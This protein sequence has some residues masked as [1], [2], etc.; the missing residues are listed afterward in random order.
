[1]TGLEVVVPTSFVEQAIDAM[2]DVF[3][4]AEVGN[5]EVR[6]QPVERHISDI[7]E[8]VEEQEQAVA[9]SLS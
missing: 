3:K 8:Y 4:R 2:S 5:V 6:V 1:M 9:V 7:Q